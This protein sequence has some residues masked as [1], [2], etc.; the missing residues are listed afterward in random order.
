MRRE[1]SN[2]PVHWLL[3]VLLKELKHSKTKEQ[4]HSRDS[5]SAGGVEWGPGFCV[6]K[7]EF[8]KGSWW[9]SRSSNP[10]SS[11]NSWANWGPDRS[12]GRLGEKTLVS[13]SRHDS[14]WQVP[15]Q[16]VSS[17]CACPWTTARRNCP[18][19]PLSENS[20]SRQGLCVSPPFPAPQSWGGTRR[21][22]TDQGAN[23]PIS[24]CNISGTFTLRGW[25]KEGA[26][27][28][29]S[30]HT[31]VERGGAM[32]GR[33]AP[34]HHLRPTL[35]ARPCPPLPSRPLNS[36][37]AIREVDSK[38]ARQARAI[39]WGQHLKVPTL[40]SGTSGCM[41]WKGP[42]KWPGTSLAATENSLWGDLTAPR[43]FH[44]QRR[45]GLCYQ[46]FPWARWLAL[47]YQCL[48]ALSSGGSLTTD[49]EQLAAL[50]SLL[51]AC[52]RGQK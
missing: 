24:A 14:P 42:E 35:P 12:R 44:S 3:T 39:L 46:V 48:T 21:T 2:H 38:V 11:W 8:P 9:V 50:I 23:L 25:K 40:I 13:W 29:R 37:L 49:R 31:W 15:R 45:A 30:T 10:I 16:G 4:K 22:R 36:R 20:C 43:F 32:Q 5:N 18:Y 1:Q 27:V 28:V 52:W 41:E 33:G 7:K 26:E 6:F 17:I 51:K 47:L 19:F 34:E